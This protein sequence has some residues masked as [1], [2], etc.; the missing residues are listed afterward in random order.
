VLIP[1]TKKNV[2]KNKEDKLFIGIV[3]FN[4]QSYVLNLNSNE[5]FWI[6][7]V[8]TITKKLKKWQKYLYKETKLIQ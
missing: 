4:K 5:Q 6:T 3:I 1:K 7:F 8:N 2:P